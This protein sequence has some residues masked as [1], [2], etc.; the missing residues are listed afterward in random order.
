M[1]RTLFCLLF[2]N[3]QEVARSVCV[4]SLLFS[5][6]ILIQSRNLVFPLISFNGNGGGPSV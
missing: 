5:V 1:R 6:A 3:D 2:G 4:R